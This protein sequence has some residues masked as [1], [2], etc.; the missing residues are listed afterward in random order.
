MER[1]IPC[2]PLEANY[3]FESLFKELQEVIQVLNKAKMCTSQKDHSGFG[4]DNIR[5]EVKMMTRSVKSPVL[6][7]RKDDRSNS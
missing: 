2:K 4:M 1:A 3:R 5:K 7:S 6:W